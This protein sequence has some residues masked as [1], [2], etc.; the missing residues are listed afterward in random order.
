MI[1]RCMMNHFQHED[2]LSWKV[3]SFSG[4]DISFKSGTV[5]FYPI[6]AINLA[7]FLLFMQV[8]FSVDFSSIQVSASKH[9]KILNIKCSDSE[10]ETESKIVTVKCE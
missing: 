8:L 3:T 7:N 6:A 9:H 10:V 4:A 1:F 5:A 2:D